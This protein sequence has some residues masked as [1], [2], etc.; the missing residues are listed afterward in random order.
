MFFWVKGFKN[1][2]LKCIFWG[3]S[4]ENIFFEVALKQNFEKKNKIKNKTEKRNYTLNKSHLDK[5]DAW[6]TFNTH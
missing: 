3:S 5:L 1:V 2:F 6:A 4:F